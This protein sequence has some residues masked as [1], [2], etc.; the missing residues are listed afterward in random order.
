M[1]TTLF[2]KKAISKSGNSYCALCVD[3][4]YRIV[5]LSSKENST[6]LCA[7]LL[8]ISVAELMSRPDGNYVL[9]ESEG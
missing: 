2:I 4:G 5:F 9:M 1:K 3:L 6:V 8:G 7:E